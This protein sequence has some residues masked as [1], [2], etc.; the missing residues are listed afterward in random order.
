MDYMN[1]ERTDPQPKPAIRF[2]VRRTGSERFVDYGTT[3]A[4]FYC[5]KDENGWRATISGSLSSDELIKLANIIKECLNR[6]EDM[7]VKAVSSDL[8]NDIEKG[9]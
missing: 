2:N 9:L 4:I 8:L 6:Y 5:V 7:V 3:P 1:I